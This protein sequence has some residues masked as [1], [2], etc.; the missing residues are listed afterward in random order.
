MNNCGIINGIKAG[1]K[2]NMGGVKKVWFF[3][4]V[5]YPQSRFVT[6]GSRLISHPNTTIYE[7]EHTNELSIT[8]TSNKEQGSKFNTF[9]IELQTTY[10]DQ[11][12]LEK[13]MKQQTGIIIQDRN[14]NYLIFG[15]RNGLRCNSITQ[16][17]GSA[18]PDFTG[19][20]LQFEGMEIQKAYFIDDLADAGFSPTDKTNYLQLQDTFYLLL[21]NGDYINLIN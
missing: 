10:K 17:I 2:I 4:F 3:T 8:Q 11:F 1:C 7:F 15:M 12:E 14:G 5:Q 20:I 6:D 21:E 19:Y 16:S 13:F 18:K 9:S